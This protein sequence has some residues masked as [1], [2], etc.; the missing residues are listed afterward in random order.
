MSAPPAE[1]GRAPRQSAIK[2]METMKAIAPGERR[3]HGGGG[4]TSRERAPAPAAAA[5]AASATTADGKAT[6]TAAH[7]TPGDTSQAK[8]KQVTPTLAADAQSAAAKRRRPQGAPEISVLEWL[9]A[10]ADKRGVD[11]SNPALPHG[12]DPPARP[13]S[14]A[15]LFFEKVKSRIK[16]PSTGAWTPKQL[17]QGITRLFEALPPAHQEQYRSVAKDHL[18]RYKSDVSRL[19]PVGSKPLETSSSDQSRGRSPD[20]FKVY[21]RNVMPRLRHAH[22]YKSEDELIK[23]CKKEWACISDKERRTYQ[24]RTTMALECRLLTRRR[25]LHFERGFVGGFGIRAC[26]P[27]ADGAPPGP[28]PRRA[29]FGPKTALQTTFPGS[30]VRRAQSTMRAGRHFREMAVLG[31]FARSRCVCPVRGAPG[32]LGPCSGALWAHDARYNLPTHDA[33]YNLWCAVSGRAGPRA[34][35]HARASVARGVAGIRA[36]ICWRAYMR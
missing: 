20:A 21:E 35:A 31:R 4:G 34:S 7:S 28:E 5:A 23:M 17:A 8:R 24:V 18:D 16:Q 33:R 10:A 1:T 3:P 22:P 12:V 32:G 27:G 14:A 2:M 6:A 11:H 15:L 29:R 13:P 26:A 30:G 25:L 9:E 19:R 36:A